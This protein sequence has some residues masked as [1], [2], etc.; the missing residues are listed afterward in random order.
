[1]RSSCG[2]QKKIYKTEPRRKG[3]EEEL[4]RR[5]EEDAVGMEEKQRKTGESSTF[6]MACSV[7]KKFLQQNRNTHVFDLQKLPNPHEI[8][9][10]A[11][12]PQTTIN[13][14][15]VSKETQENTKDPLE[16][17]SPQKDGEIDSQLTIFYKGKVMV[18]DHFPATKMKDLLE[19]ACKEKI[20]SFTLTTPELPLEPSASGNFEIC[21]SILKRYL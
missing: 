1:M 16:D 15:P 5:K 2:K 6:S 3:E 12:L 18:Y 8:T 4:S 19:M 21:I 14:F 11:H 20:A 9:P 10:E 7:L 17:A 13:L